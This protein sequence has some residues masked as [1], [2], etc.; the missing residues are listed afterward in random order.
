MDALLKAW[1]ADLR[2]V[3]IHPFDDSNGRIARAVKDVLLARADGTAQILPPF[4]DLNF[5]D[6]G[7]NHSMSILRWFRCLLINDEPIFNAFPFAIFN[8][9]PNLRDMLV[10]PDI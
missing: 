4:I 7:Q 1:M 2:F 6:L 3:T 5:S 8:L 9:I 10:L